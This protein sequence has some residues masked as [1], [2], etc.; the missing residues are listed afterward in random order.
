MIFTFSSISLSSSLSE[1]NFSQ[2]SSLPCLWYVEWIFRSLPR[3]RK[4]RDILLCGIYH[5]CF[6][7][8]GLDPESTFL[9]SL[10]FL[11]I[12]ESSVPVILRNE[13][14]RISCT[15]SPSSSQILFLLLCTFYQKVPKDFFFLVHFGICYPIHFLKLQNSFRYAPL[16]QL[17]FYTE[18]CSDRYEKFA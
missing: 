15:H 9:W 12:Q 11:C 4:S 1:I 13:G 14:S 2:E 16:K 6:C 8:S 7:H 10:S 18:I 17:Q 5:T 3:R